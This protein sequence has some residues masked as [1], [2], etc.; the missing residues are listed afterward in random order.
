QQR[1]HR[2]DQLVTELVDPVQVEDAGQRDVIDHTGDRDGDHAD[3]PEG[4][5]YGRGPVEPDGQQQGGAADDQ[6]GL[7]GE[8]REGVEPPLDAA[9]EVAGVLR[10]R[11][12]TQRDSGD[13]AQRGDRE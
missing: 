9:V 1:H 5:E 4:A 10:G 2:V 8:E 6:V 12:D 7:D 11:V 3:Q 13:H